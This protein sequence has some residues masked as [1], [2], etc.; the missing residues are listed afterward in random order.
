[1]WANNMG[2]GPVHWMQASLLSSLLD[3]LTKDL[4]PY[5]ASPTWTPAAPRSAK[6]TGDNGVPIGWIAVA[7]LA[8][9]I[10]LIL[11]RLGRLRRLA[12]G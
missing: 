2:S 10:A 3:Q 4:E 11:W 5:A 9:A 1:M 7:V 12:L 8:A 6:P